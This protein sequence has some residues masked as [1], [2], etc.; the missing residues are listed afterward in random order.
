MST[1]NRHPV[2]SYLIAAAGV[3]LAGL[4]PWWL[5]PMTGDTPP[6]R[7][8]LVVVVGISAWL[9]GLGPGLF[10]TV[11]GLVAIIGANDSP[12]DWDEVRSRLLRFG[13]L[14]VLISV[15]FRGLH[16][17]RRQAEIKEQ[18]YRRSEGRYRRLIE[19]AGQGI[20]VV[21]Q[22]GRTSYAN[23]RLGEIL[24]L[25][26]AQ[27]IGLSLDEFLVDDDASWSGSEIQ[28]D[29]FAWHEIRL[30]RRDGAVRHAIVT[31]QAVG[32]DEV[33]ANAPHRQ[34]GAVAGGLLLMVTDVTPLKQAEAALREKESVLRS[35]YDSSEMAMGVVELSNDD[36][37]FLSA[38]ALTDTFFGVATG[39]LEGKSARKLKAPPE[40]VTTWIERL[41]E[42]RAT[43]RPVRF[44]YRATCS[45]S[46]A[47]VAAT[48]SPMES[49]GS[50][51]ALCSFIVE[52]I[53]DRKRTE[54]D[55]VD[56]KDLA[57]AASRAKDRFLAVLSHE[58]RTPLT[59]VLIAVATLL[60]S[61]PEASLLQTLEMIRRNIELEAR[62]IDDLLDLTRIVRG[63]LR[64]ELEVVDIHKLIRRA[65]E[66]CRDET[67]IAGLHVLTE[68]KAPHHHVTAD[69]ARILQVVWNLIRN[70]AKFTP[71]GG[72][73]TIR[74]I[75]LPGNSDHPG[76]GV[77]ERLAIEFEDSG[78]GIDPEVLPRIFE[79]FEQGDDNARGRSGGLGLGLALSRSLAEALGG[80]L[81]AASPG[82]GR[83]STFRLELE[84]VLPPPSAKVPKA[85]AKA[86]ASLPVASNRHDLRVLLVEDNKD[87]LRYLA[88]VL[89]KRGYQVVTA[90]CVTAA[91]LALKEAEAPFDLLLSDIELPDG[92]GLQ[93]MREIKASEP[94][95]GIAMSG[96]GAEEDLRQSREAGFFDHLTKP[97]DLNRLEHAIQSA[98]ANPASPDADTDHDRDSAPFSLRTEGNG[99]GAFKI[100]WSVEPKPESSDY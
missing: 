79:P 35:F 16:A 100:V 92:D 77:A 25:P 32:P 86:S 31:S 99:S 29:P 70:A 56:A 39:K 4:S 28:P 96:F 94:M 81:T 55:L 71:A 23:P 84:A 91:L 49:P 64:L 90:D 68:L 34:D 2:M 61:K 19:T 74:T 20:W 21:D 95:A 3:A 6:M 65:M 30:R 40:M 12:G 10:A 47:W 67:L 38:N 27:L 41:R 26:P 33:P 87:T 76:E 44:E 42:C 14:A 11:M 48:L 51:R 37:Y 60:E 13:S 45:S 85:K 75:N 22:T 62:L 69:H 83:G 72:R 80:Q 73:L 1:I 46:P 93:L 82:R 78:V 66:I 53:T 17:S 9:G 59:P 89:R 63:R 24:G 57:E 52:D 7:L 97:I 98:T 15:L 50:R 36:A 8:M 5:T 54:A 58:L 18:D 88:I 43:G